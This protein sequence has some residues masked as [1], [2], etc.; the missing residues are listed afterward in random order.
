MLFCSAGA[1]LII[2][3]AADDDDDKVDVAAK[4]AASEGVTRMTDRVTIV[5]NLK[6]SWQQQQRRMQSAATSHR[7]LSLSCRSMV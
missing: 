1:L 6:L 4:A 2:E 3:S 5:P 7:S